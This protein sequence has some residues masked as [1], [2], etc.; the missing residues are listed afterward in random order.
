MPTWDPEQYVRF[1]DHRDRPFHDLVA[2][3]GAGREEVEAVV[4]L[5]CGPG[6]LTASLL[7]RWP[8]AR[9]V[10]V[11]SS[12]EMIGRARDLVR[13]RGTDRLSFLHQDLR[14]W[15]AGADSSA[16]DVIV[17]NATLQWVPDHLDLLPD[18]V[19]L[20]RPGGWFAV[21]IPGNHDAPL[22][23]L[24]REVARTEPYAEHA[25]AASDRFS[26][27]GPGDY[28]TA[29]S[30]LGCSVDA[31]ET[32][33][34]QVLQGEDPVYEWISG[35]GARPVLQ[36]LPDDLRPRFVAEYQERL[37]AA[38]PAQPFGTVLPFRRVFAVARRGAVEHGSHPAPEGTR[39]R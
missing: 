39:D 19:D 1:A 3:V 33:Y 11:D 16:Y 28:L 10:G 9:V 13:D 18:L 23:A 24:L 35:T 7:P 31:W 14:D 25:A 2:R 26:L 37:R 29:L 5:G 27:P 15:I 36:A 6:T 38:Y 17:T 34:Y 8:H 4:D 32:T 22:H 30:A 21:Q 20:L 12:A